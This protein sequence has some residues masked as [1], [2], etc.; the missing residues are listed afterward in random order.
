MGV[1]KKLGFVLFVCISLAGAAWAYNYLRNNKKPAIES[2]SVMPADCILYLGT[3]NALGLINKINSQSIIA[4]KLRSF[5]EV[6]EVCETLHIFD[7]LLRSDELLRSELNDNRLHFGLYSFNKQLHWLAAFNIKELGISSEVTESL[8]GTLMAKSLPDEI[9]AFRNKDANCYFTLRQGIVLIS[10]SEGLIN[11]ALD[12]GKPRLEQDHQFNASLKSLGEGNLLDI[13]INHQLYQKTHLDKLIDLNFISSSGRSAGTMGIEPSQLTVTGFFDP[14]NREFI[15]ALNGQQ[16]QSTAGFLSQLPAGTLAFIAYGFD[17]LGALSPKFTKDDVLADFWQTVNDSALFNCEND[18]LR[19]ASNCLY[20][21]RTLAG[22]EYAGLTIQDTIK[23]AEHLGLMSDTALA[24]NER[25]IY[26]LKGDN[27]TL[28]LFHP[29]S[30]TAC[31]YATLYGSTIFIS[32]KAASL[33]QLLNDLEARLLLSRNQAFKAYSGEHLS[34]EFNFIAYTSPGLDPK[35]IKKLFRLPLPENP[36]TF[37]NLKHCSYSLVNGEKN[38]KFRFHVLNQAG[39]EIK[40]QR[41]LW[42]FAMDTAANLQPF[43]FVNHLNGE[44]EILVQDNRNQ[45]YLLNA[46]GNPI[47]KKNIG[48][49]IISEI[50]MVD[51]FKNKKNQILFNTADAIHLLDRNGNYLEGYP[52]RLPAT[53]NCGLSVFDYEKTNDYRILIPCSNKQ[54]YNYA[55]TGKKQEGFVPVKTDQP[56]ELPVQWINVGGSDMLVAID[57]EGRIYTFNRKG[58]PRLNL[59]N[60]TVA[61][62]KNFYI[63]AGVGLENTFLVYVDDRNSLI[64]KIAFSDKKEII[65]LNENIE[66]AVSHY[67]LVDDNRFMDLLLHTGN[68]VMAYDLGGNLLF[69]K[70]APAELDAA[71]YFSD[72]SLACI[73]SF[74]KVAGEVYVFDQLSQRT[75]TYPATAAPL[76]MDLFKNKKKYLLVCHNNLLTCNELE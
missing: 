51:V 41:V 55:I 2:L 43:P 61:A 56:V 67:S 32:P 21:F 14:G 47:W 66:G 60:R 53:A 6:D 3:N 36:N 33:K 15:G 62:C 24:H 45:I 64:N 13:Y 58:L 35:E 48:A 5:K 54:I 31:G 29:F 34:E 7:S 4:D 74:S 69:E 72:E 27:E 52:A 17:S 19:N 44:N 42:T 65:R 70:T 76:V 71:G 16:A 11:M 63:D 50:H 22:N 26:R 37:E 12:A 1:F 25:K 68:A 20:T 10:G 28:H 40:T 9:Y 30:E 46:K 59:R 23:A 39:S 73:Y 49:A 75:H 57:T 38:F 18:F 8:A